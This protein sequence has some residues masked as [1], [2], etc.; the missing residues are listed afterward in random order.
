[1]IDVATGE[2]QHFSSRPGRGG[3]ARNVA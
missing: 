1:L 3:R 2:N